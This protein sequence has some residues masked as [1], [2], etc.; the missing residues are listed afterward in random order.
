MKVLKKVSLFLAFVI[1]LTVLTPVYAEQDGEILLEVYD[2][3]IDDTITVNLIYADDNKSHVQAVGSDGEIVYEYTYDA[4][5]NELVSLTT[6][7]IEIIDDTLV[8]KEVQQTKPLECMLSG[9]DGTAGTLGIPNFCNNKTTTYASVP[10]KVITSGVLIG[11]GLIATKLTAVIAAKLGVSATTVKGV[12]LGAITKAAE[13]IYDMIADG[14]FN[15]SAY[16]RYNYVCQKMWASD[17]FLPSGGEWFY[18][19]NISSIIYRGA[20]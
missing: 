19:M 6:D 7:V 2:E 10:V 14:D 13:D 17:P 16:F 8:I 5:T 12:E 4:G 3:L 1:A 15:R 9:K 11:A 18:G 20:W